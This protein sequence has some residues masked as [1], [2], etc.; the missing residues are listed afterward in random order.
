MAGCW[1]GPE[2]DVR[3]SSWCGVIRMLLLVWLSK[4]T[5]IRLDALFVEAAIGVSV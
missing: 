2:K 3:Y 4:C 1:D 5:T